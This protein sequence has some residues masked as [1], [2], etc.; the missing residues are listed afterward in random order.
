MKR[1]YLLILVHCLL[2]PLVAIAQYPPAAGE[3]GSTA[4]HKDDERFQG[5]A[6]KADFQAGWVKIDQ[7]ELGRMTVDSVDRVLGKAGDGRVL[8][9]GDSG[10]IVLQF[11]RPIVDGP[12][13][14]FAVFEN[15]FSDTFLEL[16]FVEVSSDGERFVRFPAISETPTDDQLPTFGTMDTRRIN[17][18]AGKYRVNFGTPFD[19]SELS[20]SAGLDLDAV[21]HVRIID[22]VGNIQMPYATYD[23]RGE[24]VNDPWPTPFEN[25]CG[26][27]LDAV[28]V[29]NQGD[30]LS[31]Q[32][33][34]EAVPL[35]YPNPSHGSD[36]YF[37]QQEAIQ[38]VEVY[39][40]DGRLHW[41]GIRPERLPASQWP[42]GMYH[43]TFWWKDRPYV[44]R[45][46]L[47]NTF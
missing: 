45:I 17:N 33:P 1:R 10:I 20:D 18:L 44:Q 42:S 35:C 15:A 23:S 37:Q 5:W 38:K 7:Q 2:L 19:L 9:F 11:A 8:S 14:D 41:S 47:Q 40:A 36:V 25:S 22:V 13:F 16:A 39:R 34:T 4:I 28:G 26:F 3:P 30:L 21:T 24:P 46:I 27:D 12:G 6:T 43:V 29:I 31:S 32:V